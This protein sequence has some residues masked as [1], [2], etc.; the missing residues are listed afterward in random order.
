MIANFPKQ[1]E[2]LKSFLFY[3]KISQ[4]NIGKVILNKPKKIELIK[5]TN[6]N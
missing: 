6:E 2:S 3:A 5:K 4:K 1:M